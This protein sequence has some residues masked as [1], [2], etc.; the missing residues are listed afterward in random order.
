MKTI[1]FNRTFVW[2]LAVMAMHI[3]PLSVFGQSGDPGSSH[4]DSAQQ[5]NQANTL[6]RDGRIEEAIA[7]YQQIQPVEMQRSELEYNLA[8]AQFRKGDLDAAQ[9]LF[10][11]AASSDDPAIAAAS[12]YNLGNC[13]YGNAL[14]TAEQDKPAAIE[15]LHQ[16]I[17]HYRGS[18][19]S[20]P[21][22]ADARAN[23][24]LAGQLIRKLEE[25]QKQDEQQSQDQE[26]QEQEKKNQEKQNQEQNQDQSGEGQDEQSADDQQQEEQKNGEKQNEQQSAE[27]ESGNEPSESK[28][29]QDGQSKENKSEGQQPQDA[30][31][32]SADQQSSESAG[33][34][35]KQKPERQPQDS[36]AGNPQNRR[37]S[38][39][40]QQPSDDQPVS[41]DGVD[42]EDGK[43]Q[44]VPTGQLTAAGEKAETG[45]PAGSVAMA[46]PNVKDEIMTKEEALKML[47]AVRDRDMLRRLQQERLERSRHVPVDRDW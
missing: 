35:S 22:N 23:I 40:S 8:V 39:E 32:E 9:S 2:P 21:D 30:Q 7:E 38:P 19:R 17:S 47:Q 15:Q 25:E 10:Q 6:V 18:L 14:T 24:E 27:T 31:S 28:D 13:L 42:E 1:F 4:Q 46:N 37:Q 26:K 20:N 16:A 41:E 43:N 36:S 33:Q 11:T 5:I 3:L 34:P 29:N 45:K 44:S 12:R